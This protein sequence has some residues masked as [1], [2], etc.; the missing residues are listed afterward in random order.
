MY[1]AQKTG[2]LVSKL[3]VIQP[4]TYETCTD[5]HAAASLCDA[6]AVKYRSERWENNDPDLRLNPSRSKRWRAAYR[7]HLPGVCLQVGNQVCF[8]MATLF[9]AAALQRLISQVA[10]VTSRLEPTFTQ[11]ELSAYIYI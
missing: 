11:T 9:P 1:V 4:T 10:A 7:G 6:F 3:C 2:V 8:L 5:A